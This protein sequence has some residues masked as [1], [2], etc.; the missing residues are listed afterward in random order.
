MDALDVLKSLR[1]AGKHAVQ[2]LARQTAGKGGHRQ[3][4]VCVNPDVWTS[5]QVETY[6]KP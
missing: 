4:R 6:P 5:P 2:K 3:V 1:R